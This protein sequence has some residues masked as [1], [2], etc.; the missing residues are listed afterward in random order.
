MRIDAVK[1]YLTSTVKTPFFFFVGDGQYL[2]AIDELKTCGLDFVP[3]SGFA[4]GDKM[5]DIDK[6]FRYIEEAD[7]NSKGKKFVVTGLGEFLALRGIIEAKRTLS[8]LK[9]QR[10]GGAKVIL[11]LRGL[12]AL[13][14]DMEADPRFDD[15]RHIVADKTMCDLSFIL[16][17][18]TIGLPALNGF[19]SL[20][21]KLESGC[22]GNVIVSTLVNLENSMFTVHQIIDAYEGIQF[23]TSGLSVPRSCGTD[24][25]WSTL[26]SELHENGTSLANIFVKYEIDDDIISNVYQSV[27]GMSYRNWLC[28][29]YLKYNRATLKNSYLCFAL[30]MTPCFIGFTSNLLNAIIEV[31]HTD[32]RFT[33]FYLERKTLVVKFPESDIAS[34]VVNNRKVVSE[35][36][37]RLT[38]NTKVEQEEIIAWIS[39]NGIIPELKNIYPTL[40]TYL[41]KYVFKCSDLSGLLTDY[42]DAY[43]RQKISNNLEP[44]FL[45]TIDDLAI[46]RK[47]NRLPTRDEIMNEISEDGSYLYWLDALGVEYLSLIEL[48]AQEKGLSIQIYIGR[49]ELPTITSVN[50]KFYDNWQGRKD[51]SKD[52]D[53]VKHKDAGGYNFTSNELPI[54]LAQELHIVSA[55]IDRASTELSL[56][57][58]KHFIIVSDHGA[59][60][61]AVIRRKEEQYDTD[62]S[63]KHSGRCCKAFQPYE[64]PFAA[65]ENG[66]LVLADYGRFRGGRAANVEV[67]GGASLEEVVVPVIELQLNDSSVTVK[68]VDEVAIIDRHA[69][70]E[71]VLFFNEL[72][73]NVSLIQNGKIYTAVQIDSNH[74]SVKLSDIKRAGDYLAD[75][76]SGDNQIGSV[77]I[78][79]QG[80]SG[81]INNAFE[82][83]F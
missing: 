73:E 20:L 30:D 71:I 11:L 25:Q 64:L 61:L 67:H 76:Y 32:S 63:G 14:P 66:Y 43:K 1:D 15:R 46:S 24:D 69:G 27:A 6:L 62:T 7:M 58:C 9:D 53:D 18:A 34:Y 12:E 29:I 45:D 3:M 16:S 82:D 19:D 47:F 52:L 80:R 54:H 57:R 37:Y 4:S 17:P 55:L 81:K 35:S 8:K 40:A 56:R 83:L 49:A 48:L 28:F 79:V 33:A 5:P 21:M 78:K 50:R 22:I 10:V 75:I 74:Y 65:E 70:I 13:I 72:V 41:K 2:S 38:D 60:R 77:V 36:I 39:K 42:F 23:I 51:Q 26:L 59:S 44:E 31:S 68:L